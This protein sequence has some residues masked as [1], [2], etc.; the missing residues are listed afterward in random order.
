MSDVVAAAW[1]VSRKAFLDYLEVAVEAQLEGH[2]DA[3]LKTLAR[4][5]VGHHRNALRRS[6]EQAYATVTP[7]IRASV[8]A[9]VRASLF[10]TSD[11]VDEGREDIVDGVDDDEELGSDEDDECE[12]EPTHSEKS[13]T[14]SQRA[15]LAQARGFVERRGRVDTKEL[16]AEIAVSNLTWMKIRPFLEVTDRIRIER[17]GNV[18]TYVWEGRR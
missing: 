14:A 11:S 2:F 8:G 16:R 4:M 1:E 7:P 6:V 5:L 17:T 10:P 3:D 15:K 9:E 12:L 13:L 18:V